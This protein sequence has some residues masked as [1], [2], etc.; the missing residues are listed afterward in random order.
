MSVL[1]PRLRVGIP[2]TEVEYQGSAGEF[3]DVL[4]NSQGLTEEYLYAHQ[5]TTDDTIPVYSTSDVPVGR[6]DN[7]AT[8]S[9]NF[10]PI[11][12]PV[13]VVARKGYAGRLYV[14]EAQTLIVHEDAYAVKPKVEYSEAINLWWFAGHYSDEFQANRTSPWGIGDFPRERF[15]NMEIVVPRMPFQETIASLY[16]RR[17]RLLGMLASLRHRASDNIDSMVGERIAP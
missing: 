17:D 7:S 8:T 9:A 4:P 6:L 2:S 3:F 16:V 10:N 14:V 15:L 12:G 13:V 11:A 1:L 5:P